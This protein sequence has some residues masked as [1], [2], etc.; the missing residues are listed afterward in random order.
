MVI[1]KMLKHW[2][3]KK[4]YN[5]KNI[6]ELEVQMLTRCRIEIISALKS[7]HK[8]KSPKCGYT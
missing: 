1:E 8:N 4:W 3:M 7:I 5:S 2:I 6:N